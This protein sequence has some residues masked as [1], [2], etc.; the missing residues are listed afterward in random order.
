MQGK[1]GPFARF[2]LE[3]SP[4]QASFALKS[5]GANM[6]LGLTN[7]GAARPVATGSPYYWQYS[8]AAGAQGASLAAVVR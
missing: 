5:V 7:S 2:A 1:R 6:Y 3:P 8:L 4:D